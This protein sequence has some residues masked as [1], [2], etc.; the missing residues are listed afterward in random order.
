MELSMLN[1]IGVMLLIAAI[2]GIVN[3]KVF[4]Q[5]N[6]I[7]SMIATACFSVV[8]LALE[9]MQIIDIHD[10]EKIL[11]R[12]QFDQLLIHYLL[13]PL[14][15]AGALHVAYSSLRSVKYAFV[16]YATFGVIFSTIIC[17]MIVFLAASF[18]L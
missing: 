7:G 10:F 15:F 5:S 8:L 3:E 14:L 16:T 9:S 12:I 17:G 4:K 18:I 11:E 6:T 13:P 1:V 2:A